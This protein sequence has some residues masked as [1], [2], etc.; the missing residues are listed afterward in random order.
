MNIGRIIFFVLFLVWIVFNSVY[1][2]INGPIF[3]GFLFMILGFFSLDLIIINYRLSKNKELMF[4]PLALISAIFSLLFFI[5]N[6]KLS[7]P[8][9]SSVSMAILLFAALLF[10]MNHRFIKK[11]IFVIFSFANV[12]KK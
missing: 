5:T 8:A 12:T 3:F 6:E 2:F 11:I 1:T 7:V 9:I 10:A 4:F